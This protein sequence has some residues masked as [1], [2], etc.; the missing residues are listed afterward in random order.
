MVSIKGGKLRNVFWFGAK[1]QKRCLKRQ[2]G[3]TVE[4]I[5]EQKMVVFIDD[6]GISFQN[7]FINIKSLA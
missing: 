4:W 7:N 2:G 5:K 3:N 1:R 6:R